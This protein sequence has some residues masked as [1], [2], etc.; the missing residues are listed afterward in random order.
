[1]NNKF[2]G[3]YKTIMNVQ[4][5]YRITI[6][7]C[8]FA[9]GILG[10]TVEAKIYK[11]THSMSYHKLSPNYNSTLNKRIRFREIYSRFTGILWG[12]LCGGCIGTITPVIVPISIY[13]GTCMGVS[14][15][16]LGTSAK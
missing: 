7:S 10:A 5:V 14:Y 13:A 3:L 16:L 4:H 12:S 2:K 1:M 9:G 11:T 15:M 6:A 8:A